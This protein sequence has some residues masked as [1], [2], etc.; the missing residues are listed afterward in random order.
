MRYL[1]LGL[2]PL[3][4]AV[5]A[6]AE[7]ISFKIT[8]GTNDRGGVCYIY[9]PTNPDNLE[10]PEL[11]ISVL[12]KNG[13]VNVGM[14][15]LPSSIATPK[16]QEAQGPVKLTFGKTKIKTDKGSL[17]SGYYYKYLG[18]WADS[19]NGLPVLSALKDGTTVTVEFEGKKYGPIQ[20]QQ[21]PKMMPNYGY[22][23]L[24][25]CIKKNGGTVEF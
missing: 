3:A 20:I 11:E 15:K 2:L 1:V 18:W 13:N 22:N 5:S 7:T 25:S 4:C 10:E 24:K 6:S 12:A 23:H 21:S 17:R 19:K 16:L 9:L 8:V 14:S